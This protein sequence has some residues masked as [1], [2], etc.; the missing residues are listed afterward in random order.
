MPFVSRTTTQGNF[1][2]KDTEPTD[3]TNADLWADSDSSPRKLY[4][5]NNGTALELGTPDV[6]ESANSD[7]ANGS[8]GQVGVHHTKENITGT[9]ATK[10]SITL[11][12]DSA[13]NKVILF[14]AT[15]GQDLV[16]G[17]ATFTMRISEGGSDVGSSEVVLTL[18]VNECGFISTSVV[19]S[20]VTAAA[21]TYDVQVKSNGTT[22]AYS[23]AAI[24][25]TVII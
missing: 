14:A 17:G 6:D 25:G 16:N 3:W 15:S 13:V 20:N 10:A 7:T 18:G 9:Y 2:K 4:I 24:R 1:F 11:T 5:N 19:L 8:L 23:G 21:H 22:P 12:P